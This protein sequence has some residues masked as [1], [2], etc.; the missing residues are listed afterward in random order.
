M[1]QIIPGRCARNLQSLTCRRLTGE[2]LEIAT[3]C[4]G[5]IASVIEQEGAVV[6]FQVMWQALVNDRLVPVHSIHRPEDP[7][8]AL[9][10]SYKKGTKKR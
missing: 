3:G 10:A 2:K 5:T 7:R 9:V 8:V 1:I 6:S 4:P